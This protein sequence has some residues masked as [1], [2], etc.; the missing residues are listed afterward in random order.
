ML[1]GSDVI[2]SRFPASSAARAIFSIGMVKSF[3]LAGRFAFASRWRIFSEKATAMLSEPSADMLILKSFA[4]FSIRAVL[5]D[6]ASSII[7]GRRMAD[8]KEREIL[9]RALTHI[10][11]RDAAPIELHAD[12]SE[13]IQPL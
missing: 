5:N 4:S 13:A 12:A 3:N 6:A 8:T 1:L 10:E 11:I 2:K 7:Y 9:K